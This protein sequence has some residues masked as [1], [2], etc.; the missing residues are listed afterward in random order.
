MDFIKKQC[1]EYLTSNERKDLIAFV[2][3]NKI[4]DRLGMNNEG[5]LDF[6]VGI[7]ETLSFISTARNQDKGIFFYIEFFLYIFFFIFFIFYLIV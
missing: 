7:I 4:V 1:W 6:D 5:L 3:N 2:K